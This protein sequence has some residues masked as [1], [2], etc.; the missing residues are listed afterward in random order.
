LKHRIKFS[1]IPKL[2]EDALQ[3]VAS[4]TADNL[5]TVLSADA[6]ARA[7]IHQ[8]LAQAGMSLL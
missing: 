2:I 7:C 3:I 8:Q 5:Q 6:Q 4:Q 1:D